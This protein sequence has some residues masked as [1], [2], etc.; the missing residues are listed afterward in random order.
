MKLQIL[1]PKQS[2]NK[3][4]LREKIS[5][6]DI[7]LFKKNLAV[8]LD[9]I[10]ITES[11]EHHKKLIERKK[12]SERNGASLS[13]SAI[14]QLASL[15]KIARLD[16]PYQ[17]GATLQER[18]FNIGLELA[19]TWVNRILFLKLLEAQLIK[20]HKGD[21]SFAFL[22]IEKVQNF[23]DLDSLF[24]GVLARKLSERNADVKTAFANVP[25]LNSSLFEPTEIEQTCFFIS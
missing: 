18:L 21:Q 22:N 16:K 8:L 2:L 7:E 3:A 24:F 6:S 14:Q 17:F 4:Y 11:E 25:Y 20:Y 10:N 9:K 1:S 5:R 13:E 12:E 15:D 19:I 23:D